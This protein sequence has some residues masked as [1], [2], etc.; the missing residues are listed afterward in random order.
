MNSLAGGAS[1]DL[2]DRFEQNLLPGWLTNDTYPMRSTPRDLAG[3]TDSVTRFAPE[4][5]R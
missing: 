3:A 4:R 1:E 5:R 2:G